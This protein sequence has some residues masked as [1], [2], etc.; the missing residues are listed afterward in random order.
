[1]HFND[2]L[3]ALATYTALFIQEILVAKFTVDEV[4]ARHCG[5]GFGIILTNHTK[6]RVFR[7][8]IIIVANFL[9]I[10]PGELVFLLLY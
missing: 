10:Y 9:L 4:T 6:I 2:G 7:S 8:I 5:V 3:Y 1:M